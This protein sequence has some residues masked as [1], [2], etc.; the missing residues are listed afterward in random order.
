[1]SQKMLTNTRK[2][3]VK[4]NAIKSLTA[5]IKEECLIIPEYV[6]NSQKNNRLVSKKP[7]TMTGK[8]A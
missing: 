5:S 8:Y 2:I 4:N 3:S 7:I 6:L 1:M